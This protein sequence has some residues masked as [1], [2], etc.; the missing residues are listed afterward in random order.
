MQTTR[1]NDLVGAKESEGRVNLLARAQALAIST[2]SRD[3]RSLLERLQ[4]VDRAISWEQVMKSLP[5]PANLAS[6]D[7]TI[8]YGSIE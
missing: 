2:K 4:K 7:V 3:G 6:D 5:R 1:A 8:W